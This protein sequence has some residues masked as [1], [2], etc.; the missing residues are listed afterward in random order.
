MKQLFFHVRDFTFMFYPLQVLLYLSNIY[1]KVTCLFS[2][3]EWK[4]QRCFFVR[5]LLY[6]NII[7]VS[8]CLLI[9]LS[10]LKKWCSASTNR[11]YFWVSQLR[12]L[13]L[14]WLYIMSVS[15]SVSYVLYG[16]A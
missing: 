2:V 4:K 12:K 7:Q 11:S 3:V 16:K 9:L 1:R 14:Y 13:Q 10:L 15:A 5:T 8:E 6:R